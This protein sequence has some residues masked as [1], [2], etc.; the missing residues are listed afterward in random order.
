MNLTTDWILQIKKRF[1]FC[2]GYITAEKL[3]AFG[4][5][6]F[7]A[8]VQWLFHWRKMLIEQ[9]YDGDIVIVTG[10]GWK[11]YHVCY[12]NKSAK[13]LTEVGTAKQVP[14]NSE[15]LWKLVE[16]DEA[17]RYN[18][19]SSIFKDDACTCKGSHQQ[20]DSNKCIDI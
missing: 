4:Y 1:K 3:S 7:R 9:P 16:S 10:S 12:Y 20:V 15:T 17:L 13:S 11:K 6:C 5:D 2:N 8:G 14:I 18:D 19:T